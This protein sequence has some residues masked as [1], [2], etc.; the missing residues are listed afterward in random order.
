MRFDE[1]DVFDDLNGVVARVGL[2]ACARVRSG[3][4]DR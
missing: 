4:A 2:T 1:E 3:C